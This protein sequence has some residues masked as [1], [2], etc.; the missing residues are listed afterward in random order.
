MIEV[1]GFGVIGGLCILLGYLCML[2]YGKSLLDR[3]IETSTWDLVVAAFGH[4]GS[5]GQAGIALIVLGAF[6]CLIP[7]TILFI[8]AFEFFSPL[9]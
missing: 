6:L 5:W 7:I 4:G 9:L 1:I 2:Q 8:V 3:P